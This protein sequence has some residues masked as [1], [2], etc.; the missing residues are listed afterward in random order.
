[1]GNEISFRVALA[2]VFI[3]TMSTV[4]YHRLRAR[5]GEPI[6]RRQ[7]GLLLAVT[8]RLSGLVLWL[9]V[10]AYLVNPR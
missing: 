6:D 10:L 7:E 9:I 2:L 8:L 3:L 4:V 5:T 1:M